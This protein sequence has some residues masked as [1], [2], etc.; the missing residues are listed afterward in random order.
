[1]D[2]FDP[3]MRQMTAIDTLGSVL[4]SDSA[5]EPFTLAS[6]ADVPDTEITSLTDTAAAIRDN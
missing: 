5:V 2:P 6:D 3:R 4:A 1:M